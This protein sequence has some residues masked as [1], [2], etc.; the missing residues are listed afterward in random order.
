MRE[1]KTLI[2]LIATLLMMSACSTTTPELKKPIKE[3]IKK[4]ELGKKVTKEIKES[5]ADLKKADLAVEIPPVAEK[6]LQMVTKVKPKVEVVEINKVNPNEIPLVE[7]EPVTEDVPVKE[8]EV[9][10]VVDDTVAVVTK[11]EP[12]V[13]VVEEIPAEVPAEVVVDPVIVEE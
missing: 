6:K 3:S 2:T 13:E 10:P 9:L 12:E 1:N 11:A 7:V 5:K 4:T 8:V